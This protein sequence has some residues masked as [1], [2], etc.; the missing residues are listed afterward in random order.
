MPHPFQDLYTRLWRYT[1]L[2]EHG[3]ACVTCC[4]EWQGYRDRHGYGRMRLA[5][6]IQATYSIYTQL[7]PRIVWQINHGPIERTQHV[8]H[9]CDNPP[10]VNI[11]HLWLGDA[12]SNQ[13]D[14][15]RK[16][17]KPSGD[18][19]PMRRHPERAAFG[20][21]NGSR[22]Y[23]ERMPR[24]TENP[25]ARLTDEA[26]YAMRAYAAHGYTYQQIADAYNITESNV[27]HIVRRVTWAHLKEEDAPPFVNT[28]GG[29]HDGTRR[30]EAATG[31]KLTA[32][33][34]PDIRHLA[35]SGVRYGDI[36]AQYGISKALVCLIAQRKS[37]AHIP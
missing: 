29:K 22:K 13:Q 2:C 27:G 34:I 24:G 17:R 23:R 36:A 20:D 6:K 12:Q 37:W 8:C 26:V 4:H 1:A 28:I 25:S 7:V 21:R 31:A 33:Q 35:V 3:Q 30:G 14:S 16:D 11:G 10:C 15:M 32:E 19:H 18:N 5:P 9:S